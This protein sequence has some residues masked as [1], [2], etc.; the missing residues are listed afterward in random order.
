MSIS[1]SNKFFLKPIEGSKRAKIFQRVIVSRQKAELYTGIEIEE[2]L[3]EEAAQRTKANAAVNK[4]LSEKESELHN[5]IYQLEQEKKPITAKVVKAM[6]KGEG[7]K[8]VK[9]L[10]FCSNYIEGIEKD[11]EVTP[12][13]VWGYKNVFD[14]LSGFTKSYCHGGDTAI[15]QVDYRFIKSFDSYLLQQKAI[16]AAT[17]AWTVS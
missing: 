11:G 8:E 13:T 3:W 2:R 17:F 14:H 7:R 10:G 4:R 16:G 6:L 5:L 12:K 15:S 9:L 1:Y